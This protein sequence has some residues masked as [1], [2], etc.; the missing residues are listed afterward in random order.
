MEQKKYCIHQ[1]WSWFGGFLCLQKVIN[2]PVHITATDS[3][4]WVCKVPFSVEKEEQKL[5]DSAQERIGHGSSNRAPLTP[6]GHDAA[7][8]CTVPSTPSRAPQQRPRKTRRNTKGTNVGA[9]WLNGIKCLEVTPRRCWQTDRKPP[10][11]FC[12]WRTAAWSRTSAHR[13]Q[14]TQKSWPTNLCSN[15]LIWAFRN[16]G[17]C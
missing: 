15:Y 4:N 12:R 11:A 17:P 13:C 2:I 14:D 5:T 10:S 16:F 1:R 8:V 3:P 6:R 7:L 9:G